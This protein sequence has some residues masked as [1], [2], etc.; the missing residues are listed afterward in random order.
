MLELVD[1]T[2]NTELID[3]RDK[4]AGYRRELDSFDGEFAEV[5]D[6]E[7]TL[8]TIDFFLQRSNDDLANKGKV[9]DIFIEQDV[10][11][12]I[13]QLDIVIQKFERIIQKYQQFDELHS[14]LQLRLL[15]YMVSILKD[16]CSKHAGTERSHLP[17][18][19]AKSIAFIFTSPLY[20]EIFTFKDEVYS[21]VEQLADFNALSP[22]QWANFY[23][24]YRGAM[25]RANGQAV[26]IDNH[27]KLDS[28]FRNMLRSLNRSKAMASLR[29]V[30]N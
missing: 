11:I 20:R 19:M 30:E 25:L 23:Q 22:Q 21:A 17:E 26:S 5:D 8:K 18:E 28:L 27:N 7:N 6:L 15:T 16:W 4:L 29:P 12:L 24:D 13:I 14:H 2:D 10:Q 9:Q 3:G 1:R